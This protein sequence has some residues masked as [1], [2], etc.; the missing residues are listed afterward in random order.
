MTTEGSFQNYKDTINIIGCATSKVMNTEIYDFNSSITNGIIK[1]TEF[2]IFF[3][4]TVVSI[5]N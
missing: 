5:N 2:F 1:E 4:K 3:N